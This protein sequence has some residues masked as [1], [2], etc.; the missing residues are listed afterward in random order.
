MAKESRHKSIEFRSEPVQE[1]LGSVPS[2]IIRWGTTLFFTI[3]ILLLL[4]S[5]L[6]RYPEVVPN[7][8]IEVMTAEPPAYVVA[9]ST[10]KIEDF[11]IS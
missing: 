8:D 9:S 2:W 11:F 4:G 10:G 1:I 7:L 3:I 6:F 5:W